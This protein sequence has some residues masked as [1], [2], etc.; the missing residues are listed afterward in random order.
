MHNQGGTLNLPRILCLHGG[1]TNGRIFRMQCRVIERALQP[2]FRL[3]YAEASLPAQPGSDVTSVYKDYG[4]FRTWLH[5]SPG[6]Q[7][8]SA[9]EVIDEI[10]AELA[11]A[12]YLDDLKGATGD[13]VALLGFSQGAKIAASLLYTQQLSQ[14]LTGMD[15]AIWPKFKFAVLLAGRGPLVWLGRDTSPP[16]GLANAAELSTSVFGSERCS[17]LSSHILQIP[18]VHVHGSRDPG[19]ELHR[20]LHRRNCTLDSTTVL[21]FDQDHRVPI[22]TRDVNALVDAICMMAVKTGVLDIVV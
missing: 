7:G 10:D 22:K 8:R 4:P 20:D 2:W 17:D 11:T 21:E 5:T 3:V 12:M 6:D 1:G 19:L 9:C 16:D 18:T 15:A 13:W 14:K